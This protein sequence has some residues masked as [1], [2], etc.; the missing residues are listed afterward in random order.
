MTSDDVESV[1]PLSYGTNDRNQSDDITGLRLRNN[2]TVI[3]EKL[4]REK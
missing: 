4:V 2:L 3:V 1:G